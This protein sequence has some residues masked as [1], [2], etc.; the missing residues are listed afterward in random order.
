MPSPLHRT[1]Q[2]CM[3][4]D[5]L[6]HSADRPRHSLVEPVSNRMVSNGIMFDLFHIIENAWTVN[7]DN[8]SMEYSQIIIAYSPTTIL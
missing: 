6:L 1:A 8:V 5:E 7:L 4:G 3:G 2:R